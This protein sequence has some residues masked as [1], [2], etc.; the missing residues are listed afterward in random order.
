[1]AGLYIHIPFCK[2]RCIYCAFYSSTR[3]EMRERYVDALCREMRMRRGEAEEEIIGTV[4]LGGGTPSLLTQRQTEK[5]FASIDEDYSHRPNPDDVTAEYAAMIG[6]LPVNRVSMGVQSFD[7][8]R[9]R[10]LHRRHKAGDIATAMDR[11]RRN[12]IGNVSIDL[13]FGF[14]GQTPEEW[15]EDIG[16]AIALGPEH[17]SA[18]SLMVEEGTRLERMIDS[19]EVEENDEET[20]RRMYYDLIDMLTA[21]GYEHYEISNFSLPGHRSRHNSSYWDGTPYLGF[22]AAAH[23]YNG[24]RRQWNVDNL[25]KYIEEIEDGR[26][27]EEHEDIDEVTGYNDMITTALRTAEG[28]D[29]STIEKPYREYLLCMAA[30]HVERGMLVRDGNRIHLSREGL[31]TSNDILSDLIFLNEQR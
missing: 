16:K 2:S 25:K 11:L 20:C 3:I 14:P 18:Y 7:D 30:P 8:E 24:R 21:A 15:R 1:M 12:G 19:G 9:L 13:M 17:I 27:P 4:Y 26:V 28:I 10:F 22:G 6:R 23:S 31:Y 5:V 29:V